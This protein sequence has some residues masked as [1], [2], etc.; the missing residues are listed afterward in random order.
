MSNTSSSTHSLRRLWDQ[1]KP[2]RG[3]IYGASAYSVLNKLFDLA[4]PA[5]I[6][7]AVD[8]VVKQEESL[9]A[10]MGVQDVFHQLVILAVV[11]VFVWAMESV[12]EYA[13][14]WYWRNLAQT[15]QHELRVEAYGH[16]QDLQMSYF[17]EQSTGALM[18]V[19]NDDV[20]QL[21]RFLDSGANSLIQVLTTAIVIT[22]AFFMLA[23]SVAWMAMLPIPFVLWGSFK[24]QSMLTPLY[25]D[26]RVKVSDLNSQ[27]SNNLSGIATIK[28]FTTEGYE[29]ERVEA[30]SQAYRES[31]K[32]AIKL[33]SA[34]APLIRIVIVVG[35]TTTL[36]YGGQLVI[37]NVLAVGTYSVLVFLTQR[38][39][40]PLTRLGETFDLYQRAMASTERVLNLLQTPIDIEDGTNPL[41]VDA[42]Q[43]DVRFAHINFA[44]PERDPIL[45]DFELTLHAGQTVG[46]VGATG[47]GK[48]TLINLLM[49]FYDPQAG[50]ICLDG[51]RIQD[52]RISELRQGVGLVSQSTFLFHGSV[53]DNIRYGNFEATDEQ[54]QDAAISAEAHDFIMALPQGYDTTIGERGQTLSGGQRQRISIAR[55]LLKDPKILIL[56]E[57]TS[58]VDNET[59]A[60]LQRSIERIARERTTLIIAHRLS[61]VRQAD[62]IIVLDGGAIVEDGTHDA[63]VEAKGQYAH[64]WRIQTGQLTHVQDRG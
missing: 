48:T 8:I 6:G 29:R 25:R 51:H 49:R 63:L 17:H 34:F 50:E 27:L 37:D 58:A 43:G 38:L 14:K 20:N 41:P 59:E 62:R 46:V 55:V 16:I 44:Y 4:P 7:V 13:L 56:D 45:K 9:L 39:L 33:S 52:L 24:F 10:R 26:V 2:H 11:T 31:N 60:A 64:L 57:A 3:T 47:A 30:L 19:L 18:S 12:F 36:I 53:R 22:I 35:F 32:G 21:E 23:P 15:I 61:T 42:L 1:S 28:S 5:L 40:W 54:I